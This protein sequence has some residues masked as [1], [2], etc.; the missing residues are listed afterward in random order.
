MGTAMTQFSPC[1]IQEKLSPGLLP[2][3]EILWSGQPDPSVLLSKAD[4]FLIP[5]SLHCGGFALAWEGFVIAELLSG[6]TESGNGGS[7]FMFVVF[8][9][10]F[11]VAGLY[12]IFGRFI[13]KP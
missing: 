3:E 8:G 6:E 4:A 12:F 7:L 9:L 11:V 2:N 10:I 1:A 5:F 13:Y